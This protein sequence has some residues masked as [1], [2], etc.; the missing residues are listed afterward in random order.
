M[1]WGRHAAAAEH[2]DRHGFTNF[3]ARAFLRA[4]APTAA[5]G[6]LEQQ[7]ARVDLRRRLPE[8]RVDMDAVLGS[9]KWIWAEDGLTGERGEGKTVPAIT[10][11]RFGGDPEQPLKAFLEEHRGLFRHGAEIL[12]G[13]RKHRDHTN[14]LGVRTVAWEQLV[15]GIPV[16]DSVLVAHS[17]TRGELLALSSLFVA[18]PDVAAD[19]GTPNRKA[20]ATAPNVTA[21]DAVRRA[22]VNPFQPK[23]FEKPDNLNPAFC[24]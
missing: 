7:K 11:K 5:A 23:I 1:C 10:A 21:E 17:G 13:A 3:D 8:V 9:P 2:H 14:S 15:D 16:L 4:A 22:A 24:P 20:R 6:R 12:N 18:D 19:R